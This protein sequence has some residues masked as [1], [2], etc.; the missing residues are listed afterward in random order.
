MTVLTQERQ[1]ATFDRRLHEISQIIK[2]VDFAEKN[3]LELEK[4]QLNRLL[5]EL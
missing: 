4:I 5:R 3:E 2:S 1:R